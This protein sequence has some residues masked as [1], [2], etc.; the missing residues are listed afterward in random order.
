MGIRLKTPLG[1]RN[2]NPL[3]P[4]WG[5]TIFRLMFASRGMFAGRRVEARQ[6]AHLVVMSLQ[7]SLGPLQ[8]VPDDHGTP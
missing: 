3:P 1:P 4:V 7:E 8:Q 5:L 2:E 6:E